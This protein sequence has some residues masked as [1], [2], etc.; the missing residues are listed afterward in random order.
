LHKQTADN[1]WSNLCAD[2]WR[3]KKMQVC[4]KQW[5]HWSCIPW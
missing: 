4:K 5:S 1:R 3:W 2:C